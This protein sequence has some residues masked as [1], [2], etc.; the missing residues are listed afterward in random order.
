MIIARV[1]KKQGSY[2]SF[3]CRGHAGFDDMGKD[4]VCA[5]VSM[6]VINTANSI[7]AFTDNKITG[8]DREQISWTF[9]ETPDRDAQLLMD[10]MLL[11]LREVVSKYGD[12]YLRLIVEEV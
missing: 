5:A 11:G 6:L 7:E 2:H 1:V 12:D 8:S 3:S 4:I 9:E 10:S